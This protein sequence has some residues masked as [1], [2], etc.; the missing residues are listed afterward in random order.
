MFSGFSRAE[1]DALRHS[2]REYNL[3]AIVFD[4][5]HPTDKDFTETIKTLAGLSY[6]VVA[7]ITNP[8][9]SPLELQATVPDYQIP[10]VPSIQEGESPFAMMVDLQKK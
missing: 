3:M 9:S 1:L 7:D 10:F 8:K 5:E 4:F 6:F 2:L